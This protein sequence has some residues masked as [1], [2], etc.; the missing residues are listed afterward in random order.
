MYIVKNLCYTIVTINQLKYKLKESDN[1]PLSKEAAEKKRR[2][3]MRYAEKNYKR[4]PLDLQ[5]KKY[6]ELKKTAEAAGE[7][8]NG[9]IKK[10][11]ELRM[12]AENK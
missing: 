5:L 7:T 1:M 8:V 12:N 10:A 9:Y 3:N 6:E 4:V 11:I 2:Y